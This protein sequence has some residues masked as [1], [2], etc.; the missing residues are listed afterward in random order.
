MS[1]TSSSK[2]N[3]NPNFNPN[4]NWK[5]VAFYCDAALV[6]V[7]KGDGVEG[8]DLIVRDDK[9]Q[10]HTCGQDGELLRISVYD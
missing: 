3:P 6:Q 1:F 2:T 9:G 7:W 5:E 8:G 4:P 10:A